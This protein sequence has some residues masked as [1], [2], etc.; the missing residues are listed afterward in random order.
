M[1]LIRI[2]FVILSAVAVA[3]LGLAAL[4]PQ[5][6]QRDV[7]NAQGLSLDRAQH[8][9][10]LI[11]GRIARE[12]I[13]RVSNLTN[14]SQ[15]R[16]LLEQANEPNADLGTLKTKVRSTLLELVS[17]I[18]RE[19][20][21]K[22]II[23]VDAQG[24]LVSR[25]GPGEA[26]YRVGKD[27]LAGYPLVEAA[28][29]GYKS[30]DTWSYEENLYFVVGA[31]VISRDKSRYVGAVILGH[32][33]D[34]DFAQEM[35]RFLPGG[36]EIA[37]FLR[38][39]KIS[40]TIDI[41]SL[42]KLPDQY[43]ER[44]DQIM[45][46]E[47]SAAMVIGPN[48]GYWVVIAPLRGEARA[49]DA[50]YTVIA[51]KPGATSFWQSL[52]KVKGKDLSF[53]SFPWIAVGISF[54][55]LIGL[56]FFVVYAG[57]DR[58]FTEFSADLRKVSKGEL[59]KID[60]N[61]FPFRFS[62]L[63][64]FVNDT[65]ERHS[66]KVS[67]TVDA[68]RNASDEM[69]TGSSAEET[70]LPDLGGEI[71]AGA[72]GVVASLP[73]P[74]IGGASSSAMDGNLPAAASVPALGAHF[75]GGAGP[76]GGGKLSVPQA[77]IPKSF[78]SD[79]AGF[80]GL[81]QHQRPQELNVNVNIGGGGAQRLSSLHEPSEDDQP[82][83]IH[84]GAHAFGQ[85][86]EMDAM[87]ADSEG[88]ISVPGLS[89][90]EGLGAFGGVP[91]MGGSPLPGSAGKK[92]RAAA[93]PPPQA[94]AID[95]GIMGDEAAPSEFGHDV[96]SDVHS[97]GRDLGAVAA[98]GESEETEAYFR[99]VFKEFIT[100]KRQC[101][102]NTKNLT[103]ERFAGKLQKNRED[104]VQRYNCKAVKFQVYIKDGKAALKATPVKD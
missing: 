57:W 79:L 26:T 104:L 1:W 51:A 65:I 59:S 73:E 97:G 27:G 84:G 31:P 12:R 99:Q 67:S 6:S 98:S 63:A 3:G 62:L 90:G 53:D 38:G 16:E 49:H 102:E 46:K 72:A 7:I 21:P 40:S 29:R 69:M 24:I 82:T 42:Q 47:R 80:G 13:D 95:G 74:I 64:K 70:A 101:G 92:S 48:D 87:L 17:K 15:L 39:K 4:I 100:I 68:E 54:V 23:A 32:E 96:G 88:P 9:A 50:F 2:W 20:Q 83:N 37:Y 75:P 44:R 55:L 71:F 58:H 18:R 85:G 93:A 22:L 28:L 89:G 8:N 52:G 10:D 103:Y 43:A 94:D 76:G 25:I 66:R 34:N 19:N 78:N 56:S 45:E 41:P 33:V 61:K 86:G 5:S 11:M 77:A 14:H 36:T 91:A 81:G 30:D 60:G 35:K